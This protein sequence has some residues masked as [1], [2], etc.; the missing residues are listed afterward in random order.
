MTSHDTRAD[1][2]ALALITAAMSNDP[3]PLLDELFRDFQHDARLTASILWEVLDHLFANPRMRAL[4]R[5]WRQ[6]VAQYVY[7]RDYE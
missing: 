5:A 1:D 2:H 6:H 7:T 3:H 4:E